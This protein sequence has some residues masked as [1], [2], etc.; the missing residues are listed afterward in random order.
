M[1]KREKIKHYNEKSDV[2]SKLSNNQIFLRNLEL[3]KELRQPKSDFIPLTARETVWVASTYK[4]EE[5]EILLCGYNTIWGY[6]K[7]KDYIYFCES[8]VV[9]EW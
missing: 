3:K 9:E 5:D 7:E 8:G 2:D 4:G 1:K 6:R